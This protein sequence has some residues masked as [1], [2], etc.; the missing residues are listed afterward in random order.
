VGEGVTYSERNANLIAFLIWLKRPDFLQQTSEHLQKFI[1]GDKIAFSH[2]YDLYGGK[3][4]S[5]CVRYTRCNDDARDVFQETF[6]AT[7]AAIWRKPNTTWT[8]IWNSLPLLELTN[9]Y[10]NMQHRLP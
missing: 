8:L 1:E 10:L 5:I 6:C 2:L 4:F 7:F 3:V 9:S